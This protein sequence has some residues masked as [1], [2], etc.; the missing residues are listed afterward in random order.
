MHFLKSILAIV[1]ILMLIL[2]PLSA[3]DNGSGN[4]ENTEPSEN[5]KNPEDTTEA[6]ETDLVLTIVPSPSLSSEFAVESV[7]VRVGDVIL[8]CNGSFG[9]GSVFDGLN[10]SGRPLWKSA[11]AELWPID[12]GQPIPN[13]FPT[14][15]VSPGTEIELINNQGYEVTLE[16]YMDY[17]SGENCGSVLPTDAGVYLLMITVNNPRPGSSDPTPSIGDK[18]GDW[19]YFVVVSV[20][21]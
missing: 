5:G 17:V 10:E 20:E 21:E 14:L 12:P 15:V 4:G 8:A 13:G 18:F 19:N 16:S 2:V 1:M 11:E 7:G 6:P 3:C 9:G